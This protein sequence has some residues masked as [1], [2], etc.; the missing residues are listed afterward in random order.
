MHEED[1]NFIPTSLD[2][3]QH[4]KCPGLDYHIVSSLCHFSEVHDKREELP[5]CTTCQSSL[6]SNSALQK[7]SFPNVHANMLGMVNGLNIQGVTLDLTSTIA[8]LRCLLVFYRW[9][10]QMPGEVA[11][12]APPGQLWLNEGTYGPGLLHPKEKQHQ[13]RLPY[14]SDVSHKLNS[15]WTLFRG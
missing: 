1:S 9:T 13:S 10:H 8:M 4:R 15:V 11:S 5:A 6:Y 7:R 3:M 2:K 12:R 14:G